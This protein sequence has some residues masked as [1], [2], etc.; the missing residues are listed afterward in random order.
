M[1][2]HAD[3]GIV[4]IAYNI[5]DQPD[6]VKFDKMYVPRVNLGGD[7]HVNTQYLYRADGSKLRKT[8][9]Y[10]SGKTNSEVNTITEYLDGFQYEATNTGS[11]FALILKFVPTSE[12]YY[13]FEKNK[14]I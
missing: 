5:M 2:S 10:G 7:Y 8:Y 11:K 1:I 13:D 4:E 6:F 12:G 3:K 9:T 14:Y